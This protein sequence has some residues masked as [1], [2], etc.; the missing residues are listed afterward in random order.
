MSDS[1]KGK[2]RVYQ[3]YRW[4][5]GMLDWLYPP[6]CAGCGQSGSRWC[7]TC[8]V[9]VTRIENNCCPRCGFYQTRPG[10]C[11]RCL[12][13]SPA[14]AAMRSWA[15]FEGPL[16]NALHKL[17]YARDISLGDTLSRPL[18]ELL[19]QQGWQVDC[20]V[21]V[22]LGHDRQKQRGYNQAALLAYPI[23]LAT[24]LA[25]RPK[26]VKKTMETPSQVGLTIQQRRKNVAGVF[27]ADPTVVKKQR[28]L[29]VDDVATSGA[30]IE[31]CAGAI[32]L[33]EADQVYGLTLA[34]AVAIH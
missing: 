24:G 21:P 2:R 12:S 34:Q 33:A 30:T 16:R 1:P 14:L 15:L 10:L 7:Q 5:W 17:K 8:Q 13:D 31:S 9:K 4:L 29:I 25:Y 18:V 26:A 11:A 22:P 27:L 6:S 23:A 32:M 19:D 20:V 28:V 3:A